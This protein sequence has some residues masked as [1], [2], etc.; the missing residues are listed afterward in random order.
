MSTMSDQV[1]RYTFNV[2]AELLLYGNVIDSHCRTREECEKTLE[3]LK[4][5]VET[6]KKQFEKMEN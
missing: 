6:M 1:Y 5:I 2:L 4:S 3:S